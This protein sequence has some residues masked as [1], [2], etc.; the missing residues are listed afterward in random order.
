VLWPERL[1]PNRQR[2]VVERLCFGVAILGVV[3]Q[4]Q[5][6][7]ALGHIRML[8]ASRLAAPIHADEIAFR[9]VVEVE[10]AFIGVV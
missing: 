1:L 5:A 8:G 4:R 3:K 10:L 2:A 9:V 6:V 7:E